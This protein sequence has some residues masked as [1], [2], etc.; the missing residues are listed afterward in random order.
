MGSRDGM[1]SLL[2]NSG[3]RSK[4]GVRTLVVSIIVRR[5]YVQ[6]TPHAICDTDV[7]ARREPPMMG[8]GR[9]RTPRVHKLGP[10]GL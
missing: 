6:Y 1:K 10:G 4:G 8:N 5:V 3:S 2:S 9:L 7:C